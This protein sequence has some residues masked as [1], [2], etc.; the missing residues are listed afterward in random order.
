MAEIHEAST[1]LLNT[2]PATSCGYIP[3]LP[4]KYHGASGT[5]DWSMYIAQQ[6]NISIRK[7]SRGARYAH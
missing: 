1:T 4:G 7:A 2:N 3:I 5:P 6:V